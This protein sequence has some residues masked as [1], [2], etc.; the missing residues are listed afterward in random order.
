[1]KQLLIDHWKTLKINGEDSISILWI[2]DDIQ[3][4][5]FIVLSGFITIIIRLNEP[6]VIKCIKN[7]A[8]KLKRSCF[9]KKEKANKPK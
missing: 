3:V 4:K 2:L 9:R 6:F 7:D 1:M 8:K 5:F